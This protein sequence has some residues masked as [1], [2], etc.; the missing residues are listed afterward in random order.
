MKFPKQ[1]PAAPPPLPPTPPTP[2][3][4][5]S[6]DQPGDHAPGLTTRE[7]TDLKADII[8]VQQLMD[9][10]LDPTGDL[11]MSMRDLLRKFE[12]LLAK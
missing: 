7:R 11:F 3:T 12:R 1:P 10:E 2:P 4:P 8:H 6:I 9:V 5:Q